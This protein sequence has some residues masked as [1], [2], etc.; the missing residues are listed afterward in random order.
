MSDPTLLTAIQE[1][2]NGANHILCLAHVAPDGDAV[3]SLLGLGWLL[4][5]LGKQP[6][7]ALQDAP[8]KEYG[9]LPAFD[10]IITSQAP[11]YP[12]DVQGRAFDLVICTDSS[13]P[14]RMGSVYNP[15]VHGS[16]P[17]ILID[18]HVTNT[19]FGAIN[20]V[21]PECAAACQMVAYLADAFG[22]S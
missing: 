22:M 14:D 18:H 9:F 4:R 1:S 19:R 5:G 17:L 13:S 16:V 3:G 6:T 8:P 7:L 20:W 2:I 10:A 11:N 12:S 15:Q 21:A